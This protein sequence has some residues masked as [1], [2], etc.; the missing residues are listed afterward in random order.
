MNTIRDPEGG[1][2]TLNNDE[3]QINRG[4]ELLLSSRRKS[5]NPKTFQLMHLNKIQQT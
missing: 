5:E 3:L 4:V 1:E 2:N